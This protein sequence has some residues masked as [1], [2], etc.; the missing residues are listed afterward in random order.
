MDSK[1]VRVGNLEEFT[2]EIPL[3]RPLPGSPIEPLKP[4]VRLSLT[5][6]W[7]GLGG[8]LPRK[9]SEL[10]LQGVSARDEIVWLMES[11]AID[12]GTDAPLT[13]RDGAIYKQVRVMYDLVKAHLERRG[14]E[15]RGGSYGL[16]RDIDPLRGQF[17]CVK[18][19]KN[20]EDAYAVIPVES[21]DQA[22]M[23]IEEA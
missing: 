3:P 17:E 20:G 23:A 7:Q 21:Q 19:T 8:G 16:P 10:H 1:V 5:E 9:E 12:W 14:Y 6:C 15:V 18:W 13:R 2:S 22:S 4:I 11:H